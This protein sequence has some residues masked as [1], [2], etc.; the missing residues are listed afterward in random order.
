MDLKTARREIEKQFRE[1]RVESN[2]KEC[3]IICSGALMLPGELIPCLCVNERLAV[4][5]WRK[6]FERNLS[7]AFPTLPRVLIWRVPPQL[8]TFQMTM[9]GTDQQQRLVSPRFAIYSEA[10]FSDRVSNGPAGSS[11]LRAD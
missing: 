3:S 7:A 9:Q 1:V 10:A 8:K 6:T 11:S 4:E 2:L 5:L